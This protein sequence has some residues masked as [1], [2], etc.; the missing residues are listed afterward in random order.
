M[1]DR[2]SA[3]PP[4]DAANVFP[5][6]PVLFAGAVVVAWLLTR[7]APLPW[8]GLDD[9]PAHWVGLGF[10]VLGLLLIVSAY[11]ALID[12]RTLPNRA[13]TALVTTGPYARFR[14]PIYL[15]E[16]L[17]LL[18]GAELTKSIWFVAAAFIFAALVTKL[19]IIPEERHLEANFGDEYLD[20][21]SRS[22]RWI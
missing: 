10:G 6:A 15:G 14:N 7:M 18:C 19:Q 4:F 11:K 8:P 2:S 21:K 13:S 20:Y 12:H 22:R 9:A 17:L 5:W 16:V 1:I 3:T